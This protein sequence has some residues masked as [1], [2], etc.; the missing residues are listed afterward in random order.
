MRLLCLHGYS[1][2][3]DLLRR[4]LGALRKAFN[5]DYEFIFINGPFKAEETGLAFWRPNG[6]V[7]SDIDQS[8]VYIHDYI[9]NHG[10]FDGVIGFSQGSSVITLYQSKYNVQFKVAV[11]ISASQIVSKLTMDTLNTINTPCLHICGVN[12]DICPSELSLQYMTRAYSKLTVYKHNGAHG[13]PLDKESK[14]Y[15]KQFIVNLL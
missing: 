6:N 13:I 8:L 14:L 11:T 7:A 10:P 5:K 1:M 12:D 9:Q 2:D 15:F 3:G 4:K